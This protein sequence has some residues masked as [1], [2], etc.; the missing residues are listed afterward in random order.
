MSKSVM[1]IDP[2]V[3]GGLA[4]LKSNGFIL[5]V[6]AFR[7]QMTQKEL[8]AAVK[9][10][11][12]ALRQYGG[13]ACF[14]EKVGY[15]PGDG[16]KGANTFGR[17]DGLLRGAALAYGLDVR[18]VSP[19]LWQSRMNCL[20]GGNKNVTKRRAQELFPYEAKITHA[21]ADALLIAEYGRRT[22]E[23]KII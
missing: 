10:G 5:R 2:G 17:I 18:D 21:I 4:V 8:V 7:P 6:Q 11:V 16:G 19:M 23:R 9:S 13:D 3:R 15:M 22:L 14:I 20:S 12:D 1:G